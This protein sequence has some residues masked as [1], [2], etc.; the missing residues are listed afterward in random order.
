MKDIGGYFELECRAN[1]EFI[2]NDGVLLNTCRN[3]LEYLLI[4]FGD[5]KRV[6]IPYYTCEVMLEP[7]QKLSISYSF[8]HVNN[9]LEIVEIIPKYI[10]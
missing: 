5:V 9:H 10:L 2:H 6:W 3:A 1:S 8:Y 7:L 4:S